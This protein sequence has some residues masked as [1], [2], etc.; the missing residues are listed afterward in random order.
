MKKSVMMMM[1]KK[2]LVCSLFVMLGSYVFAQS[3]GA[4]SDDDGA[5]GSQKIV[6]TEKQNA[7]RIKA[8]DLRLVP[9]KDGVFG[10]GGYHLYVRKLPLVDS[11]LLTETTKD[12]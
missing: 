5:N 10:E 9:E 12:P 6:Y 11:I 2:V 4:G 3:A 1:S 8:S 7:M